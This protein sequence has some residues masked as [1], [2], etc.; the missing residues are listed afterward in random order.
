MALYQKAPQLAI[1]YLTDYSVKT[2]DST[3]KR[4]KK[5]GEHLIFKYLDGNVKNELGEVKHPGYPESWYRKIIEETGEHFKT[6][7][8]EDSD[9]H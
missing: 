9:R 6:R 1:N 5:L 8:L 3:V 2:G 7:T 4:W